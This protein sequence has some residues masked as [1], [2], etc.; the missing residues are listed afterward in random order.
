MRSGRGGTI[1][2]AVRAMQAGAFDYILKPFKLSVILPVLARALDVRR[3]RLKN[4][5]L[6][7]SIR[8]RSAELARA[9]EEL[10][11]ASLHKSEFLAN[12]SHEL[13]TPL[14]SIIGFTEFIVDGKSGPLNEK[15]K[16]QLEMAHASGTHL[17]NLINDL[18]DLSKIEA[19]KAEVHKEWIAPGEIVE[20]VLR[21]VGPMAGRKN[22]ALEQQLELPE[23][24][25][26]D[27]RMLFQILLNLV[28]NAVKFTE[29]GKVMI[30]GAVHG[31]KVRMTV[32][33][34]GIGMKAESVEKLF[35]AF[36]QVD[37]SSKRRQDG[38][39]LGLYLCK[40]LLRLLGG[41]ISVESEVGKGS[42]FVVEAP[43]DEGNC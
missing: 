14:N 12:M 19:G 24:I 4:A 17:L 39:G 11:E 21:T 16:S 29:K 10:R 38:M 37:G 28:N 26:T 30:T 20:E 27:R 25:Y 33:D 40:R 2:T 31:G 9:N 35:E 13:R 15:Q 23:R 43:V 32:T 5:S 8:K 1:D 18:L 3:L 7:R 36:R 42:R 34:T 41:E 6:E 22:I